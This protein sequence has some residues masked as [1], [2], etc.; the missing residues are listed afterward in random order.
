MENNAKEL[1]KNTND[2]TFYS[3]A[4]SRFGKGLIDKNSVLK[5]LNEFLLNFLTDN[6]IKTVG[7]PGNVKPGSDKDN[8]FETF[9]PRAL[10][11]F[12]KQ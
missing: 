4:F 12:V 6:P 7:V 2:I 8:S 10:Y 3:S 9:I 11:N 1:I 5:S